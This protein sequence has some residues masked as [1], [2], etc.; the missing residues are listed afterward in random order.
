MYPAGAPGISL[1]FDFGCSGGLSMRERSS[2]PVARME[3]PPRRSLPDADPARTGSTELLG[4]K[5]SNA[6]GAGAVLEGNA[7][8]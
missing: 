1:G 2:E 6:M 3:T 7:A 8:T 4:G 5:D